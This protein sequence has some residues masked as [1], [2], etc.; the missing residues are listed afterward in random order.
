MLK[1]HERHSKSFYGA[2][3][4]M[5][6]LYPGHLTACT[7]GCVLVLHFFPQFVEAIGD[8]L[9][10]TAYVSTGHM[11]LSLQTLNPD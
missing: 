3:C 11:L 4:V 10:L 5:L 2:S 8:K 1:Y 6:H 7:A 9:A